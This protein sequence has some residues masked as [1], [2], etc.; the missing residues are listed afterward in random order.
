MYSSAVARDAKRLQVTPFVQV[1]ASMELGFRMQE[2]VLGGT[3]VSLEIW[4]RQ[5][6]R[7]AISNDPRALDLCRRDTGLGADLPHEGSSMW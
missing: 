7:L 5:R 2:V 6:Q 1:D 4:G 3:S